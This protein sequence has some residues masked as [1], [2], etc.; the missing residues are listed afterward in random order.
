MKVPEIPSLQSVLLRI[1]EIQGTLE[2]RKPNLP[3]QNSSERPALSKHLPSGQG[4]SDFESLL[5]SP[6]KKPT[7]MEEIHQRSLEK[8]LEPDLVKAVIQIESGFNPKAI[9]PKGA[10][11]LM[12]LMPSTAKLL[13]VE[14]PLD[15]VQN[16][17]GGTTYLADLIQTFQDR[18]LA[19]AA[20]NAGPGAVRKFGGIPPYKE[21]QEYVEKIESLLNETKTLS[22]ADGKNRSY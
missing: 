8:G 17:E 20:Y 16:L 1:R 5:N 19:L 3:L 14:D 15:P 22:V 21:T 9:S 4:V 2:P 12:Q 6:E 18:K 10:M 7:L 13:G 11:G